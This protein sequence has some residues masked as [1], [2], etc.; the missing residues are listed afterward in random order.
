MAPAI[1]CR[2]RWQLRSGKNWTTR[3]CRSCPAVHGNCPRPGSAAARRCLPQ[4][5]RAARAAHRARL[6]QA[7]PIEAQEFHDPLQSASISTSTSPQ[8]RGNQSRGDV[9]QQALEA[10]PLGEQLFPRL[11][12]IRSN[13][14]PP[15]SSPSRTTSNPAASHREPT[16]PDTSPPP[17]V[18]ATGCARS[19]AYAGWT[20]VPPRISTPRPPGR[21]QRSASKSQG[22]TGPGTRRERRSRSKPAVIPS[23]HHI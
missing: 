11:R 19:A 5:R 15:M 18:A 14:S 12:P 6:V 23:P 9:G 16:H 3:P 13:K 2:L 7:G 4:P 10:Q 1:G 21:A 17:A 22:S 20:H 8:R